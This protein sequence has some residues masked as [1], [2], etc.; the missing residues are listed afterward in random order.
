MNKKNI[1][2]LIFCLL[3]SVLTTLAQ[4]S[5]V[6]DVGKSVFSLTTF[7][8][9]GSILASSHGFFINVNGEAVSDWTPFVNA[10]KAVIVDANGQKMDVEA[11][12]SF[13]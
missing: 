10:A 5:Q 1:Y 7:K 11:M 4:P 8:A 3:L 9:D 12:I 13:E 6:Q 2:L